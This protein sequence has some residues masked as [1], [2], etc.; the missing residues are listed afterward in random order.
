[1]V[2]AIGSDE[3]VTLTI[4]DDPR[5]ERYSMSVCGPGGNVFDVKAAESASPY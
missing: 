1:L 5:P 4:I 2:P 3:A